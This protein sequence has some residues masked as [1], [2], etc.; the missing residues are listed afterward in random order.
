MSTTTH[1]DRLGLPRR[2][3][4]DAAAIERAYLERSRAMHPDYHQL[5]SSAEQRVSLEMTSLLNLA[6]TTLKNPVQRADY[7]LSLQGGPSASEHK[8]MSPAF[9]EEM[10]DLRMTIQEMR[11]EGPFAVGLANLEAKLESRRAAALA[12][13]ATG[14]AHLDALTDEARRL[15]QRQRLRQTLNE[16]KYLD[17]LLADLRAD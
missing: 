4:L 14:F 2:Y 12:A 3:D 8:Q 1:F 5:G 7:L 11:E 15:S 9:L 17:G 10:L 16:M 13:L 6:Y